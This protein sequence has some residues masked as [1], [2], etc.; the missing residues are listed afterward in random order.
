MSAGAFYS[1][2]QRAQSVAAYRQIFRQQSLAPRGDSMK[3]VAL[4]I[5]ALALAAPAAIPFGLDRDVGI[6]AGILLLG[7]LLYLWWTLLLSSAIK[8]NQPVACLVPGLHRRL[9]RAVLLS[10]AAIAVVL[11]ALYGCAFGHFMLAFLGVALL[12]TISLL[13]QRYALLGVAIPFM[14]GME[15]RIRHWGKDL[16][17]PWISG[18]S[19]G[20][21][22]PL[23][24]LT[25][26]MML[27]LALR[28]A[29]RAL[30][31]Q[32][33]D[34]GWRMQLRMMR[35][36]SMAKNG[37][38][39]WSAASMDTRWS[40][41]WEVHYFATL[42]RASTRSCQDDPMAVVMPGLG[43]RVDWGRSALFSAAVLLAMLII[44]ATPLG[45][46]FSID[47]ALFAAWVVMAAPMLARVFLV[48]YALGRTATEQ[49]ILLLA[50]GMPP[51][52]QLNRQ[53]SRALLAGFIRAWAAL[54]ICACAI[55]WLY[56]VPGGDWMRTPALATLLLPPAAFLLCDYASLRAVE[57]DG[58]L[59]LTLIGMGGLLLVFRI[60]RDWMAPLP[61]SVLALI[62]IV[63][64]AVLLAFRWRRML[65]AP[66]AF[67]TGRRA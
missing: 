40:R 24:S 65:A 11:A 55:D 51:A 39:E 23:L 1:P 9:V 25:G 56:G 44:R 35:R 46:I 2:A 34:A 50:P 47:G 49:G 21:V 58:P 8:Q 62:C 48:P 10:G 19:P 15:E 26:L 59:V 66:P 64:A 31:P 57:I 38:A 67:P 63:L 18:V 43:P 30:L 32:S 28:F 13:S 54:L 33:G 61:W 29:L 4:L 3:P 27:A 36:E 42:T 52:P 22:K 60:A 16:L 6:G 37:I 12:L 45:G 53:L 17:E 5:C 7:V 14:G 20:L 41:F